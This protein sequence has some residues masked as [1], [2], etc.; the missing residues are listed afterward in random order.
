MLETTSRR[1]CRRRAD[2]SAFFLRMERDGPAGRSADRFSIGHVVTQ[3][4]AFRKKIIARFPRPAARR[5]RGI[6]LREHQ[7]AAR[8]FVR[9]FHSRTAV[10]PSL[11]N[12]P[13]RNSH[14][15]LPA[16]HPPVRPSAR[17]PLPFA[18]E[19]CFTFVQPFASLWPS[20]ILP[21]KTRT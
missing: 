3:G 19:S 10:N 15:G 4:I 1:R 8:S 18:N 14:S 5:R 12:D 16:C 17:P 9:S 13:W 7:G 21:S 11:V 20:S 6:S 2:A